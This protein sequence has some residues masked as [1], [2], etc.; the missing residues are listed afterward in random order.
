MHEGVDCTVERGVGVGVYE[1]PVVCYE[2]RI[3][4]IDAYV[5]MCAKYD[6]NK[7]EKGGRGGA[8]LHM[9]LDVRPRINTPIPR[10]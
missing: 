3:Y 10:L 7:N 5:H 8:V 4:K 9:R 6:V 1:E 2:P